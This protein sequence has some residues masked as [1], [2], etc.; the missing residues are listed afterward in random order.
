MKMNDKQVEELR[1]R[2]NKMYDELEKLD[3]QI[4]VLILKRNHLY[5][6]IESGAAILLKYSDVDNIDE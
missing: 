3:L 1:T 4:D 2:L 6:E 5:S